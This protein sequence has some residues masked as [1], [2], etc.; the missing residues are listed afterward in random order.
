VLATWDVE[1]ARHN[2][3]KDHVLI[4]Q[5]N[6]YNAKAFHQNSIPSKQHSIKTAFHQIG[7]SSKQHFIE[8]AFHLTY[9]K[10][11]NSLKDQLCRFGKWSVAFY[12]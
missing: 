8:A 9:I 10:V 7:I 4:T 2:A 5:W 11:D 3:K 1:T 12:L 6:P